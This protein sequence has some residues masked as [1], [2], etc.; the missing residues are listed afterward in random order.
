MTS[1]GSRV[2]TSRHALAYL[3]RP[4][5]VHMFTVD[6]KPA[7][8]QMPGSRRAHGDRDRAG[9]AR[10]HG[11]ERDEAG[12]SRD[13]R[14]RPGSAVRGHGREDSRSIRA[15]AAT[16]PEPE[17]AGSGTAAREVARSS[18]CPGSSTRPSGSSPRSPSRVPC[19]PPRSCGLRRSSTRRGSPAS[20]SRAEA[21]SRPTVRRRAETPW[22][23]I[24][25]I[26]ARVSTP[27]GIGAPRSLPRAPKPVSGDIVGRFVSCAAENGIEVFR[28]HDPLNDVSNLREAGAA[29]TN[30]GGAFHAGLGVQPGPHRRER[31]P[32]SSRLGSCWS[33]GPRGA[34]ND[35]TGVLL[36]HRRA[37]C[38]DQGGQ[39]PAGRLLRSGRGRYRL[40][41]PRG[42]RRRGRISSRRR[43]TRS[44]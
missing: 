19:R 7:G 24:R 41:S 34:V 22:E 32:S 29:I 23:R 3:V 31:T 6:G 39:R 40:Y 25:A 17:A 38:A 43:C 20:R 30:A 37:C 4:S 28:L 10:R 1:S 12:D 5:S 16:S 44:R 18:S 14:R 26:K 9:S 33:S 35:P 15:R 27:L 36:P 2:P 13:R 8:I 11:V 42:R 21:C